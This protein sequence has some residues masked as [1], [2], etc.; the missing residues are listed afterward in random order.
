[1][2]VM[3]VQAL[4]FTGRPGAGKT[5]LARAV[6]P[7]LTRPVLLDGDEVRTWLTPDLGYS[8]A[9][10]RA[11]LHRVARTAALVQQAGGT[12]VIALVSPIEADRRDALAL[13]AAP[14]VIHVTGPA[15]KPEWGDIPY[16]PPAG[17]LVIDTTMPL[18]TCVRAVR[19]AITVGAEPLDSS[20]N[21]PGNF[22]CPC[23]NTTTAREPELA[24]REDCRTPDSPVTGAA[25]RDRRHLCGEHEDATRRKAGLRRRASPVRRVSVPGAAP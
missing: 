12:P 7:W 24:S 9:D 22:T 10:R 3:K 8:R 19:R 13:L 11:N 14:L 1:M 23:A 20:G 25:R 18:A 6:L 2:T 16:E 15:R 17:A 5:T 4:W 21:V